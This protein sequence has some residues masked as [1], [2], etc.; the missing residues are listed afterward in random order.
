MPKLSKLKSLFK[1]FTVRN[2][3]VGKV[4]IFQFNVIGKYFSIRPDILIAW[5]ES[6]RIS[7][8]IL[9]LAAFFRKKLFCGLMD[10]MV[11]KD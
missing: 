10:F 8:F 4:V 5:G 6:Q 1:T 2:I 11:M 9:M 7:T 3:Y